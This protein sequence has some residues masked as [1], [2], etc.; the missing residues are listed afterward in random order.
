MSLSTNN[1]AKEVV[2]IKL[3][4]SIEQGELFIDNHELIFKFHDIEIKRS[5]EF[6]FVILKE[7]REELEQMGIFLIINGS[8]KDV[9]PSGMTLQGTMAYKQPFG[10]PTTLNDLVEIFTNTDKF[11]LI[12][13]VQEQKNYHDAWLKSLQ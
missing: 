12:S 11:E 3:N 7:L 6:P 1:Y 5:G 4:N 10:T 2:K 9:Y 8:R 13:T